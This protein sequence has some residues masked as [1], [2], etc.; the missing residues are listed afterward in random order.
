MAGFNACASGTVL[1]AAP[2]VVPALSAPQI[3]AKNAAARGGLEAWR[4]I[5]TMIWMGRIE[6]PSAPM[7]SM[8]FVLEQKRPNK[9]RFEVTTSNQRSLRVF[10]GTKGWK[11]TPTHE[12]APE[13]QPF[14]AQEV[15]FAREGQGIDGPLID[16][17]AKGTSVALEGVEDAAGSPT[18]RLILRLPSGESHHVW[19]DARTFLEVKYDRTSY[20][21]AGVSGTVTV[22]FRDYKKVGDLLIPAVIETGV[23]GPD[24]PMDRLVIE[25]IAL[26]P[27]LD[28][29]TFSAPAP[30]GGHGPLVRLPVQSG[31]ASS[32]FPGSPGVTASSDQEPTP[33]R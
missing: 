30:P 24:K 18:Y 14:T 5:E 4:K 7:P 15:K 16:C 8:P 2:A 29:G 13:L 9:T 21:S 6:S 22:Y 25:K 1:A 3:L 27:P 33:P 19:V 32:A 26:N 12:G 31:G 28:D 11:V 20:N 23:G 10:D 17:E